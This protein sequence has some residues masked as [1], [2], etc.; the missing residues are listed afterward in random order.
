MNLQSAKRKKSPFRL[1]CVDATCTATHSMAHPW[2]G[3]STRVWLVA[4]RSDSL[5]V[6]ITSRRFLPK[7]WCHHA[8]WWWNRRVS[9]QRTAC[10]MSSKPSTR[11]WRPRYPHDPRNALSFDPDKYWPTSWTV[12]A[13]PIQRRVV[14]RISYVF[15]SLS[16][17]PLIGRRDQSKC[18]V[19]HSN[20]SIFDQ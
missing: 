18:A 10:L 19:Y 14:S 8:V 5:I 15:G 1:K 4:R 9:M 13:R 20:V 2:S 3:F 7:A 6:R 17:N 16:G 11:R 12:G